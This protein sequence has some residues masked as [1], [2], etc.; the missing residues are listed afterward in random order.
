MLSLGAAPACA[1]YVIWG[2]LAVLLQWGGYREVSRACK[3]RASWN[4]KLMNWWEGAGPLPESQHAYLIASLDL[5]FLLALVLGF[6]VFGVWVKAPN[7]P[8]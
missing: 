6:L 4:E 3:E 8:F 2:L 7:N 5:V 1:R